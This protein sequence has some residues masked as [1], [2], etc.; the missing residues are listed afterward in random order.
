MIGE[1]ECYSPTMMPPPHCLVDAAVGRGGGAGAGEGGT[2][3]LSPMAQVVGLLVVDMPE[4]AQRAVEV[5]DRKKIA[6]AAA[7]AVG[8]AAFP[9]LHGWC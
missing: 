5:V 3:Q 4:V 1:G 6:A 2:A 7:A 9:F 8:V